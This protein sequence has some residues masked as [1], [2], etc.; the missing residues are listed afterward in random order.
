M[1]APRR[2]ISTANQLSSIH[3]PGSASSTVA[4]DGAADTTTTAILADFTVVVFMVVGDPTVVVFMVVGDPT[5][6]GAAVVAVVT[7]DT[8]KAAR[9]SRRYSIE[10]MLFGE[11]A[12]PYASLRSAGAQPRGCRDGPS[13]ICNRR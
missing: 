4:E 7:I 2:L 10:P 12:A 11:L 13:N 6:V 8:L 9:W 1:V 5:A 3:I